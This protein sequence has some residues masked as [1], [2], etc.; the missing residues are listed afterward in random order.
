M[1]VGNVWCQSH[2]LFIGARTWK[3]E[4]GVLVSPLTKGHL[5]SLG[6]LSVHSNVLAAC[7]GYFMAIA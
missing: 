3:P 6:G 7:S 1:V 4:T 5:M 2:G